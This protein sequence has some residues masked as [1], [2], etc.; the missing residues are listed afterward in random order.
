LRV[1][2]VRFLAEKMEFADL[3]DVLQVLAEGHSRQFCLNGRFCCTRCTI[4][5]V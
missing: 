5:R 1:G 3:G 2:A 4:W